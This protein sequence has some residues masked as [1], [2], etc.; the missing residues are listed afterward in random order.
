MLFA[1]TVPYASLL[2]KPTRDSLGISCRNNIVII[3]EAHNLVEAMNQVRCSA[4]VIVHGV[5]ACDDIQHLLLIPFIDEQV[6]SC[7]LTANQL[8]QSLS[9]LTH[10][11]ARYRNRFSAK[12]HT[13]QYI[14]DLLFILRKLLDSLAPPDCDVEA[15][16]AHAVDQAAA[17]SSSVMARQPPVP[18]TSSSESAADAACGIPAPPARSLTTAAAAPRDTTTPAVQVCTVND[19]TFATGVDTINLFRV[20]QFI[21]GVELIKKLNGFLERYGVTVDHS[22]HPEVV[23]H[24][25]TRTQVS[26]SARH[27]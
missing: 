10:Y 9:A 4:G 7:Q 27:R 19:F 15:G 5:R 22:L 24:P 12:R 17:R 25:S 14:K 23:I 26:V 3:D 21:E 2:H 11:Y 16:V 6:Y 18:T 13:A 1:V 20:C 8:L